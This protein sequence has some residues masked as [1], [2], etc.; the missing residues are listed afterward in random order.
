M[1]DVVTN[2]SN[3]F[4]S[5]TFEVHLGTFVEFEERSSCDACQ[6]VVQHFKVD[7]SCHPSRPASALIFSTTCLNGRF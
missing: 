7:L 5:V 3:V 4:L 1:V 6:Y 2:W